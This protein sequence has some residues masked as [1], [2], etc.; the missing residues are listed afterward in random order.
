[1][2]F[3]SGQFLELLLPSLS[4]HMMWLCTEYTGSDSLQPLG[5]VLTSAM[6]DVNATVIGNYWYGVI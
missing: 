4:G 5:L 6:R 1:M 2:T 3:K